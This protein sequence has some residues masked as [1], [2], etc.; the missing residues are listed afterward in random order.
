MAIIADTINIATAGTRVQAAH[1]GNIRS[2]VFRARTDNTNNVYI[3]GTLVSSTAGLALAPGDS[4]TL[5]FKD[6]ISTAQFWADAD[7]SANKVD[8]IGYE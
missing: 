3:G 1:K 4:L 5:G 2:I 8:F 7:A 6:P